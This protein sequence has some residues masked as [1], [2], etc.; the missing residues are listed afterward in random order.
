MIAFKLGAKRSIST[1]QL[2]SSEAGA[3]NRLDDRLRRT[4]PGRTMLRRTILGLRMEHEQQRQ[5]LN[6]RLE[7]VLD[8]EREN[9][10]RIHHHL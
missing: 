6:F 4:M 8:G 1:A 5:D 3:T 10:S 7:V 9:L 2:A